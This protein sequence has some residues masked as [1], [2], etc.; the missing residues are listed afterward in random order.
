MAGTTSGGTFTHPQSTRPAT[1]LT[2]S[3]VWSNDLSTFLAHGATDGA[4]T[5]VDFTTQTNTPSPDITTVTGAAASKLFVRVDVI[6]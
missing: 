3:Y 4:G 6:Q 5:K 2:P 1:D